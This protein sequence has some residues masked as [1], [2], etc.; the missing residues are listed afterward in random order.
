MFIKKTEM[1]VKENIRKFCSGG[2]SQLHVAVIGDYM[3]DRYI[4]GDAY[5]IS[6]EAPVPVVKFSEEKIVPGG[7]GNVVANLIGMGLS[8][9]AIGRVGNDL[10]GEA[11]IKILS[12]LMRAEVSSILISGGTIVKTRILG[13]GHQQMLRLDQEEIV[14]PSEAEIEK[15][16]HSLGELIRS[17]LKS[18]VIS[19][20]GKGFCTPELCH[21]VI[22]LCRRYSIPVFVDPK[23]KDWLHYSGAFLVTPN[24]KELRLIAGADIANEDEEIVYYGTEIMRKFRLDNLL[25]TRSDKGA[26]LINSSGSR[27]ERASAVEVYDVSGAGDTMIATVAAFFTAG[28]P[29]PECVSIANI[30]SQIVVGKIGTYPIKSED[31]LQAVLEPDFS[32]EEKNGYYTRVSPEDKIASRSQAKSICDKWKKEGRRV[33]FTNGCFDILHVG[34]ID[35]LVD[36]KKL[37]DRLV[38]AVN[39]DDSVRRLKGAGRP[40]NPGHARAKV[41]AALEAVDLVVMFDEDTPAELLSQLRPH[42]IVKGGDYRKEDVAGRE[43]SDEVVILPLTQ[44]YS[45]TETIEKMGYTK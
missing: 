20:Y 44:G 24:M 41:L 6:P 13:G 37:G 17:G 31:L 14:S 10:Y 2:L 39:S 16:L 9:T 33:I 3:L 36:A 34:H 43:Y 27:H 28:L 11:L 15:I 7:A 40:V 4:Y 18:V 38:I 32:A 26:T 30:A 23:D 8:V 35:L 1:S 12:S 19:D 25:V 29:L 21:R 5:R 22:E 42:V 45:T